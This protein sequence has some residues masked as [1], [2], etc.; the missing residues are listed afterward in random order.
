MTWDKHLFPDPEG[1]QNDLASRGRKMIVIIDPHLKV[2]QNYPVYAEAQ[3]QN[4]FVKTKEG[5]NFQG[6]CWPGESSWLD[7]L[8]PE[9]NCILQDDE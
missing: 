3:K 7:Y 9:V 8:S 2:D 6:H 1:L 4:Y 5:N